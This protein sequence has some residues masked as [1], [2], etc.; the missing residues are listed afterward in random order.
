MGALPPSSREN[1]LRRVA[2]AA[3]MARPVRVLPVKLTT[4]TS[5]VLRRYSMASRPP[6]RTLTTP[7]GRP[8]VDATTSLINAFTC[9]DCFGSTMAVVQPAANAGASE[10]IESATGAFHGA[11]IPATPTAWRIRIDKLSLSNSHARPCSVSASAAL[12][13]KLAGTVAVSKRA[14]GRTLPTSVARIW[15][16]SSA[17][18]SK[19]A[20]ISLSTCARSDRLLDQ[21]V[22]RNAR[23]AESTASLA[24]LHPPW[25]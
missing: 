23:S 3:E 25:A 13:L 2:P 15:A 12:N 1:R 8:L 4:G 19:P 7:A 9:A 10:R 24:S 22:S 6:V 16:R 5:G 14:S 11:K 21:S 17:R 20:A 18:A